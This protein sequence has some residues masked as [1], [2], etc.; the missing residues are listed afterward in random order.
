MSRPLEL[1]HLLYATP[2]VDATVADL[3]ARFGV[4]F[5]A[6]GRHPGWGTRNRILSLGDRRYLEVIGPDDEQ[7]E[8]EGGPILE[9]DRLE[10]PRMAWWAVR[11]FLMP[12]TCG[13]FQTVGFL[14]GSVVTGRRTRED[15]SELSWQITDPRVRLLG[16]VLPLVIDWEGA[17]HPGARSSGVTLQRL[18]LEHPDHE[19]LTPLFHEVGLPGIEPGEAPAIIA[20][21]AT[22]NGEVTLS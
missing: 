8:V 10:E 15:G 17:E 6:G 20:T 21:L 18:R 2:D 13:E 14:P 11:P 4:S 1:D 12:L 16:G 3:E 9:V 19:S 7:T 22:P 5:G